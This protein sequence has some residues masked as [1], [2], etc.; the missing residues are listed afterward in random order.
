[1]TMGLAQSL[2]SLGAPST[3]RTGFLAQGFPRVLSDGVLGTERPSMGG[4]RSQGKELE[5]C[6]ATPDYSWQL[7]AQPGYTEQKSAAWGSG[8]RA[9]TSAC[10]PLLQPLFGP[11]G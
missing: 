9:A 6:L 7:P 10:T 8:P 11:W 2:V 5:P 1:M 4:G 3:H